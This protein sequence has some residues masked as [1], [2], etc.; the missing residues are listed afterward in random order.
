[1]S[2]VSEGHRE[3]PSH[4]MVGAECQSLDYSAHRE[5]FAGGGELIVSFLLLSLPWCALGRLG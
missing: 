4:L 3:Y 1:M 5:L 2:P